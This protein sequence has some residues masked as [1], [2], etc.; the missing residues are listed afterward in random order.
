[1]KKFLVGLLVT[2]LLVSGCTGSFPLTKTIYNIHRSQENKFVD[3]ALFL[4]FVIFPVY[5][6]GMLADGLILNTIEFWTGDKVMALNDSQGREFTFERT[7]EGVAARDDNGSLLFV[8]QK[9]EAGAIWVYDDNEMLVNYF[10]PEEVLAKKSR[11]S[12]N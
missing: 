7:A 11:L 1:M 2:G 9:D 5:G 12:I 4:A 8:C 10:S 3:E 6:L